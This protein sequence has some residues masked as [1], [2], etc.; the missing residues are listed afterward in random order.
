MKSFLDSSRALFE[1]I[2]V[3]IFIL[4]IIDAQQYPK[5]EKFY[6]VN[7]EVKFIRC[8]TCQKAVKYLYRKTKEMKDKAT[9]K[10]VCKYKKA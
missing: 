7:E 1:V 8:E 3:L 6:A 2:L 5:K 4:S 9:T 10:K